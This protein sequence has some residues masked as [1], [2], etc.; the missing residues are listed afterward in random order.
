[1]KKLFAIVTLLATLMAVNIADANF[2]DEYK[3]KYPKRVKVET[4]IRP[5]GQLAKMIT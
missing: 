1:M 4:I 3:A 5:N 2:S